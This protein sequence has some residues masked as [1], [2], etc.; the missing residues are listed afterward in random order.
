MIQLQVFKFFFKDELITRHWI[1]N[2]MHVLV[3]FMWH[4]LIC[5]RGR[6]PIS[7]VISHG[8]ILIIFLN[9]KTTGL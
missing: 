9:G 4:K 8:Q 1:L 6:K 5:N 3:H 2:L 7:K